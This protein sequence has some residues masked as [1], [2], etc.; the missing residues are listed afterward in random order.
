MS[1]IIAVGAKR[2]SSCS[3]LADHKKPTTTSADDDDLDNVEAVQ[4]AVAVS[5]DQTLQAIV[6]YRENTS[7]SG[8]VELRVRIYPAA[9]LLTDFYPETTFQIDLPT[10]T[11]TDDENRNNAFGQ[12]L[13]ETELFPESIQLHVVFSSDARFLSCLIPCPNNTMDAAIVVFQLSPPDNKKQFPS[14]PPTPSYVHSTSQRMDPSSVPI[15][16]NE[17][18]ITSGV[19]NG[20]YRQISSMEDVTTS[21]YRNQAGPSVLLAGCRDGCILALSYSPLNVVGVLYKPQNKEGDNLMCND[22]RELKHSTEWCDAKRSSG[23]LAAIFADGSVV[24]FVVQLSIH[25]HHQSHIGQAKVSD[26]ALQGGV[27]ARTRRQAPSTDAIDLE[28]ALKPIY[29]I[30]GQSIHSCQWLCGSYLALMRHE[31]SSCLVH[32]YAV[33]EEGAFLT[34]TWEMTNER[35][36]ENRHTCYYLD[37]PSREGTNKSKRSM[38]TSRQSALYYDVGSDCLAISSFVGGVGEHHNKHVSFV[39]VWNW[40]ANVEGLL[41]APN[42]KGHDPILSVLHFGKEKGGATK[43]AHVFSSTC[44]GARI[45]MEL[46]DSATLSPLSSRPLANGKYGRRRRS[47]LLLSSSSVSYPHVS[48]ASANKDFEIEWLESILPTDYIQ[49]YGAP[50]IASTGKCFGRSIA[51]AASR[52]ICIMDCTSATFDDSQIHDATSHSD[53]VKRSRMHRRWRRFG[54]VADEKAV[55][56][57]ALTWWEGLENDDCK[58]SEDLLIAVI[59]IKQGLERGR[60]LSCWSKRMLNL[61]HQLLFPASGTRNSRY[62]IKL[63]MEFHAASLDVLHEYDAEDEGVRR[64]AVVMISD[65]SA[66]TN[67]RIFQLQIDSER[68]VSHDGNRDSLPFVVLA[69]HTG[70]HKIGSPADLLLASGYFGFELANNRLDDD[71]AEFIATVAAIRFAGKGVD[72]LTVNSKSIAAVG[73]VVGGTSQSNA[74]C[75]VSAIWRADN[76]RKKRLNAMI[77]NTDFIVWLLQL[78]DG[79]FLSWSVPYSSTSQ[80]SK[81]LLRALGPDVKSGCPN[82]VHGECL[83]L[84]YISPAGRASL[85]LHQP[86]NGPG[87]ELMLETTPWSTYGSVLGSGQHILK[88]HRS[89]GEE[90]EKELFRTDFLEH[91]ALV[92]SDFLLSF[93]AFMPAFYSQ[94]HDAVKGHREIEIHW[95]QIFEHMRFRIDASVFIDISFKSMQL[96][97]SRLVEEIGTL[98]QQSKSHRIISA[99]F[100]AFVEFMRSHAPPLKFASLVLEIGRQLEPCYFDSLFPLPSPIDAS[101]E[102]AGGETVL[103]LFNLSLAHGSVSTAALSLPL[104]DSE[105]MKR[106]CELILRY[107]LSRVDTSF[108]S[109]YNVGFNVLWEEHET[110]CD[111]FRYAIKLEDASRES[112]ESDSSEDGISTK[113]ASRNGRGYSILCGLFTPRKVTG[114]NGKAKADGNEQVMNGMNGDQ[115]WYENIPPVNGARMVARYLLK[116]VFGQEQWKKASALAVLLIGDS[117]SGLPM[118]SVARLSKLLLKANMSDVSGVLPATYRSPDELVEYFKRALRGC[119]AQLSLDR[120]SKLLDLV[121]I[122]LDRSEDLSSIEISGLLFIAIVTGCIAGRLEDVQPDK[123]EKSTLMAAFY[124]AVYVLGV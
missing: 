6:T 55:T 111:V 87:K 48:K 32:A 56:V 98:R 16:A 95:D 34:S 13:L 107:C 117:S 59:E 41:V 36:F 65:D 22:I 47:N 104:Q 114:Q 30:M 24:I 102:E 67:F 52:G 49:S 90:F 120:A 72:A 63:P 92:P 60:Y 66:E 40:Q 110:I 88:F 118:C 29:R 17:R 103:D 86:S 53:A 43:L 78:T 80:E 105:D 116:Y 4:V 23:K 71:H 51:V 14:R 79:T 11:T 37:Q 89:L 50:T 7:I 82:F 45:R 70:V 3:F 61:D 8:R 119:E 109:F 81:R 21:C 10:T 46:Y 38:G 91:E 44:S 58:E 108:E 83:V 26:S 35:L 106:H 122:L 73:Q 69:H 101:D 97:L 27:Q 42:T 84:G 99:V 28:I 2:H 121:L 123:L 64:K 20:A 18:V 93:P 33:A 68:H 1:L 9:E 112:F 39:C 77:D 5:S 74:Q 100:A 115:R 25:H 94:L 85:W 75:S 31:G 124:D 57:I 76:I 113:S 15:A 54:K 19:V 96:L 12:P 62:G